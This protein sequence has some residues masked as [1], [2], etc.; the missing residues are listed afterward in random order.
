MLT[1]VVVVGGGVVG[2]MAAERLAREGLDVTLVDRGGPAGPPGPS[3]LV[4]PGLVGSAPPPLLDLDRDA[5]ARW[6]DWLIDADLAERVALEHGAVLVAESPFHRQDLQQAHQRSLKNRPDLRW[7]E[8]PEL[9]RMVPGIAAH[10]EAG[11]V[12]PGAARVDGGRLRLGLLDRLRS[13]AVRIRWGTPAL[14]MDVR[15]DR[16][17]GVRIPGEIVPGGAVVLASG[18]DAALL[19]PDPDIPWPV[20]PERWTR[21]RV[22][23]APAP[24]LP[25]L[26]RGRQLLPQSDGS[27]VLTSA[28]ERAGF[29]AEP[30]V[31]GVRRTLDAVDLFPP[32]AE[33]RPVSLDAHLTAMT[34][35][36][37]PLL[38]G[39]R[40]LAGLVAAVPTGDRGLLLGPLMADVVYALLFDVEVPRDLEPFRPDRGR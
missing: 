11:I 31:A 2:L 18:V 19:P 23:G 26:G 40:D 32:L 16:V 28:P 38:G 14:A 34:P 5:G 9:S 33:G 39:M 36:G 24:A 29:L 20:A 21:V 27:V 12:W 8:G 15:G 4:M 35:D 13:L 22:A 6:P 30:H 7:V 37:L 25:I 3:G 1:D 10:I 17:H